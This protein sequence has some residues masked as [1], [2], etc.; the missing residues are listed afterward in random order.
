MLSTRIF[1]LACAVA[2]FV[3]LMG[4]PPT[5]QPLDKRTVFTFSG[6]ITLPG[7]T[8]PA[9]QYLFRLGDSNSSSK[10][11]QV[12]NADGTKP[13]GCSSRC[14]RSAARD[15]SIPDNAAGGRRAG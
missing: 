13:Y 5:A 15:I 14:R 6:P 3:C 2:V 4:A 1:G 7:V 8:L 9:G 12:L 11:V 10:V